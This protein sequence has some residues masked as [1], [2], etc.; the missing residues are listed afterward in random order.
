ML[1]AAILSPVF[2]TIHSRNSDEVPKC[3]QYDSDSNATDADSQ[4]D[5]SEAQKFDGLSDS[6]D[7]SSHKPAQKAVLHKIHV[8]QDDIEGEIA[9]IMAK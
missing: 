5:G 1:M 8:A 4:V 9:R 2:S 6:N 3:R 7:F